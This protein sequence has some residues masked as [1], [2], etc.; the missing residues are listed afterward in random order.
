MSEELY[1]LCPRCRGGRFV[2]AIVRPGDGWRPTVRGEFE[3]PLC[4][5][6]GEADRGL[7][8]EFLEEQATNADPEVGR[9]VGR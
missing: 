5:A 1:V 7:A 8:Q 9:E 3:C 6:T 4:H 2:S